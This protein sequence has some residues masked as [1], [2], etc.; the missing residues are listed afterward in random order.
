MARNQSNILNI[1][2]QDVVSVPMISVPCNTQYD[3]Y[4]NGIQGFPVYFRVY[5]M[6]N[7]NGMGLHEDID[8]KV[9]KSFGL[10]LARVLAKD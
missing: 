8:F 10:Y 1:E 4:L 7:D 9:S 6:V 2:R 5:I 3:F